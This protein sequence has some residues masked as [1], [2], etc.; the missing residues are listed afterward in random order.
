MAGAIWKEL[1]AVV[2]TLITTASIDSAADGRILGTDRDLEGLAAI[3]ARPVVSW[4]WSKEEISQASQFSRMELNRD[5]TGAMLWTLQVSPTIPFHRPYLEILNLGIK[6]FPPEADTIRLKVKAMSGTMIIGFGGP[7]AY[8][9]N[10]DV[11]LRPTCVMATTNPPEWQTIEFSLHQGLFRNFR[12]AGFSVHAPWIY[13]ARWA[14][15]PTWFYLFRGSHGEIQMKDLEIVANNIAHPFPEYR[16]ADMV[17]VS[18]LVR[19]NSSNSMDKVFTVLLGV[20]DKEFNLSWNPTSTIAHPPLVVSLTTNSSTERIVRARGKFLEEVSGL[21]ILLEP[22]AVGTGLRFRLKVDTAAKNIM[23]PAIPCQP[24]DFLLY[25]SS[26]ATGFDWRPF[27]PSPEL[28]KGPGWGYDRNLT[29]N[30]L[31]GL[32]ELSLATYHARRFVPN[33]QWCDVVIPLADFLCLYGSGNLVDRFQ[34]QLPP[35]PRQVIAAV[36]LVPWPRLGRYETTIEIQDIALVE[37]KRSSGFQTSY[38]QY[39]DPAKLI[40]IPLRKGTYSLLLAPGEVELPTEI[41]KLLD[42]LE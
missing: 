14:Q 8:F 2:V 41:K 15:E 9:G 1:A 42:D 7:T 24:V 23:I 16:A 11:F 12:R 29:Y 37:L 26:T 38:F 35:D 33:G 10:S 28:L 25:E 5:S 22:G 30:K 20:E 3:S 6:Y 31:K 4:L 17:Q 21:G 36:T 18:T 27:G 39:P 40:K 13:Y 34:N 32:P 19:F